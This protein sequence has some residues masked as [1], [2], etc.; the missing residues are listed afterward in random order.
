M[1]EYK[2]EFFGLNENGEDL[3]AY[4]LENDN[5]TSITAIAYGA[6]ITSIRTKNLYGDF[7]DIVLGYD[8][9]PQY[10]DG[11]S[12]FGA[13]IG[14][15]ANRIGGGAFYL[16]KTMYK[17]DKNDG[18]N[19]LH[20]G[21]AR[22]SHK[23]FDV[24]VENDRLIFKL[25]SPDG[26]GGFPANME[27]TVTYCLTEDDKLIMEYNATCD[28]KTIANFTNHSYFNLNGHANG[29][30]LNHYLKINA[31]RIT[32]N[33][34]ECV[35]TGGYLPVTGTAFDFRTPK[36][37][38]S[39]IESKEPQIQN[40]GGYD[41]NFVLKK[42]KSFDVAAVLYSPDSGRNM[43]VVT[44]K[45]GMQLYTGNKIDNIVGKDGHVYQ[46]NA[47][48]C[49]ETGYF[50]GGPDMEG[51]PDVTVTPQSPYHHITV[52]EFGVGDPF[53]E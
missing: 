21:S 12:Y 44:T 41:N 39:D 27:I 34:S 30:V 35:P 7:G 28:A 25:T 42:E 31:D 6:T 50:P 8:T 19:T 10:E 2:A 18:N 5:G 9:Q 26:D 13:F 38:G 48:L 11:E 17:L 16:D 52:F 51:F 43:S 22:F 23:T 4:T 36:K 29:N 33:D 45:P 20:G 1:K 37:I 47:G 3:L 32:E 53:K 49:L 46:K 40:F 24:K 14:R 15:Y